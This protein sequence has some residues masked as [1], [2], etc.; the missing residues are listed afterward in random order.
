MAMAVGCKNDDDDDNPV[1]TRPS[2]MVGTWDLTGVTLQ[3]DGETEEYDPEDVTEYFPLNIQLNS[4]GSGVADGVNDFTWSTSG[5]RFTV[6][7][8]GEGSMTFTYSVSGSTMTTVI[9]LEEEGTTYT[10]TLTWTK[11]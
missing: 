11:Q 1:S 5:N 8:P 6:T 3:Y 4:N 2:N 7:I 10:F 9:A